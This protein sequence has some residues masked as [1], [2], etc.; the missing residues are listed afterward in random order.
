MLETLIALIFGHLLGDFVFQT[1]KMALL[2]SEKS[3][4]GI[5]WCSFHVS[6][7][8]LLVSIVAGIANPIVWI[9]I[10]VPHW[11][12]DRYSLANK[13]LKFIGGRTFESAQNSTDQ[14]KNFDIAFT[15]IVYTVV[16]GTFH[17]FSLW[18]VL[19]FLF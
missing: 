1:K 12:I 7:Y 2:K 4:K 19:K 9:A 13:W 3:A 10:F 14:W 17:I 18:L 11:I 15:S 8:T 16:D 6:V 5:I